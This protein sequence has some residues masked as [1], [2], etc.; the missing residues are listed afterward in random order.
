MQTTIFLS[1]LVGLTLIIVGAA[2]VL[3]R[4]HFL[5]IFASYAEQRLV[6]TIASMIEILAGLA[7]VLNASWSPLPAAL[8]A[9]VGWMA[10]AEGMAFL[11]LPDAFAAKLLETFNTAGW[12]LLLGGFAIGVGLY[13]AGFGFGLW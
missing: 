3:R 8:L 9:L 13:L 11:L 7:L 6:R 4:R 10:V 1:K 5:P 2:I 12:Y